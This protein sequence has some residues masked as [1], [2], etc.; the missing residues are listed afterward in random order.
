MSSSTAVHR[1]R[2]LR[3]VSCR[4]AEQRAA[5]GADIDIRLRNFPRREI[6]F[7]AFF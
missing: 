7:A 3:L 6:S 2:D 1:G 4:G 5:R